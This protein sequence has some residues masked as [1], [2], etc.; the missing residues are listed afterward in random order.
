MDRNKN[1][2]MDRNKN[3]DLFV[4]MAALA[5]IAIYNIACG[6]RRAKCGASCIGS[7]SRTIRHASGTSWSAIRL[8][9]WAR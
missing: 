1:A 5:A 8:S 6:I 7:R 2:A 9:W 4:L 3:N